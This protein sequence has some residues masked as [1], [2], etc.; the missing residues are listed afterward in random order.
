MVV[1]SL[2]FH[3]FCIFVRLW[4]DY[5]L[6]RLWE[7]CLAWIRLPAHCV[8]AEKNI[9]RIILREIAAN[10]IRK[11]SFSGLT[12]LQILASNQHQRSNWSNHIKHDRQKTKC[13]T[14]CS[15]KKNPF[16]Q[17]FGQSSQTS[18]PWLAWLFTC[19]ACKASDC[20]GTV[21]DA[22]RLRETILSQCGMLG[23][24]GMTKPYKTHSMWFLSHGKPT[25]SEND[26]FFLQWRRGIERLGD[27]LQLRFLDVSENLLG[28]SPGAVPGTCEVVQR[29]I[30]IIMF[31]FVIGSRCI[32]NSY[33]LVGSPYFMLFHGASRTLRH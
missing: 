14:K 20:S 16:Y 30:Y 19:L 7:L 24:C 12:P 5:C 22:A 4:R 10:T 26:M 1:S 2:C 13:Q 15:V 31:I 23:N 33:F 17:T 21:C 6:G 29:Y 3:Q 28:P 8:P 32:R 27:L 25:V 18:A 11:W 9:S